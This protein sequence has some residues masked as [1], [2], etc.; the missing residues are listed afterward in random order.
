MFELI[1]ILSILFLFISYTCSNNYL[2]TGETTNDLPTEKPDIFI[3]KDII[4][5][6]E[7]QDAEWRK[8]DDDTQMYNNQWAL[9]AHFGYI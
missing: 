5:S 8:R 2:Q 1:I 9:Y 6:K 7:S 3:I 4:N